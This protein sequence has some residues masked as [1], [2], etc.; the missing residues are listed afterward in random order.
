MMASLIEMVVYVVV[1]LLAV[2]MVYFRQDQKNKN[3]PEERSLSWK[4]AAETMVVMEA[5][6]TQLQERDMKQQERIWSLEDQNRDL[7]SRLARATKELLMQN[8]VLSPPS[9]HPGDEDDE[10]DDDAIH[11]I[12]T[13]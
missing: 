6:L 11:S 8:A 10:D 5:R 13:N 3:K 7:Q 1:A 9:M 4:S 12:P 2:K